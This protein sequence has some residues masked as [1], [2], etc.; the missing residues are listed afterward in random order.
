MFSQLIKFVRVLSSET[1]PIQISF[2]FALAMIAGL[3][4]LL[5]VH[6]VLVIFCLLLFRIN[7]AAFLLGWA[8]FSGLAYLLDPLF[9]DLG[10]AVLTHEA[11]NPLWTELYNQPFWRIARFNNTIV[12]GSLLA[13]LIAFIPLLLI[14]NLL[15]RHYRSDVMIYVQN[16]RLF[17]FLK[18]SKWFSHAVSMA[19]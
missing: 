18:S 17:K 9:H 12:M 15:I 7:L 13:S 3:T 16:S 2:G 10:R 19:E 4:P 5:S 11:L 14:S 1:A 6:N 8:F